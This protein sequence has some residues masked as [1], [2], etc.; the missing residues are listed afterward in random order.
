MTIKEKFPELSK[1]LEEMPIAPEDSNP[2]D[3]TFHDL[4][5]YYRSLEAVLVKYKL[6][7]KE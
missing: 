1:F 3:I 2:S 7:S 4:D 5:D 6:E